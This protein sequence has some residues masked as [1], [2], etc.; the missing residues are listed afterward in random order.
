[1][2]AATTRPQAF[3][4]RKRLLERGGGK[5]ASDAALC[6]T[7]GACKLRA[8]KTCY[9]AENGQG[10]GCGPSVEAP[11]RG[12]GINPR[13]QNQIGLVLAPRSNRRRSGIQKMERLSAHSMN[14]IGLPLDAF[15]ALCSLDRLS[16][17]SGPRGC[18]GISLTR[19]SDDLLSPH[20]R[21]RRPQQEP[22]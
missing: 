10:R 19:P 7:R 6:V 3:G 17:I 14:L 15:L 12:D 4:C 8:C 1:M 13:R 20:G 5:G 2:V 21:H 9:P 22:V 18:V 16:N 11:G